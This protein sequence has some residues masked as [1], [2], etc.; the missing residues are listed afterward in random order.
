MM[1]V[2][3]LLFLLS[4]P[5][6]Y[7]SCRVAQYEPEILKDPCRS[8]MNE[9][10][11]TS[12]Q[13]SFEMSRPRGTFIAS[14]VRE[15]A[16]VWV[17][18]IW[19]MARFGYYNHNYVFRVIPN[20]VAQFGTSGVPSVSNVYNW[21]STKTPDCAILQP[22]PPYMPYCLAEDNQ[23]ENIEQSLLYRLTQKLQRRQ[24]RKL[25]K[26]LST[27]VSSGDPQCNVGLSNTFGTLAMSTSYN[28][29]LDSFPNGVTWNATA[30]LFIN[31]GNNS[32][33]DE[34]LFIPI[35]TI[36]N[37]EIVTQF[38]SFGEVA[39]LGGPGPSLGKL[40][41]DGNAYI[42]GNKDWEQGMAK[43]ERVYVCDMPE[44]CT[45]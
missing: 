28:Q 9:K 37:M 43:V 29:D 2:I 3:D 24:Q 36:E 32:H 10:A 18:R 1:K 12:F 34:Y 45:N 44:Q 42:E 35:C 41:E 40:Y 4:L 17:D 14:C 15:R 22:Q 19:N 8:E 26:P 6:C 38:Q 31:L 30:E 20:F 27:K 21:S 7:G 13:I 39:E 33:L 11:P 5:Y 25:V 16:P 23:I